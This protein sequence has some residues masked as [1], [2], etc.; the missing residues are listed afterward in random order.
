[1][2]YKNYILLLSLIM[3]SCQKTD[4]GSSTPVPIP[5]TDLTGSLISPSQINLSW[6]D[7]STNES[8][9]KI[10]RKTNT[11]QFSVIGTVGTDVTKFTDNGLSNNTSY[12]YR[13]YSY[14][15]GGNSPTY[16]N[17]ISINT[18]DLKSGLVAYFPFSGNV[19]DSSGNNVSSNL[20]GS[21]SLTN[22]R[23]GKNSS[24][25]LFSCIGFNAESRI[26][27]NLKT[28]LGNNFSISFWAKRNTSQPTGSGFNETEWMFLS[29]EGNDKL[30][31]IGI[32]AGTNFLLYG[33]Y[34]NHTNSN[35][36]I[37]NTWTHYVQTFSNG[38]FRIY[39]NG[40][41]ISSVQ[42][43][44]NI[45]KTVFIIGNNADL[46]GQ[47]FNGA[48]DDVRIYNNSIPLNVIEYLSKN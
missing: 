1:M 27:G 12:T 42:R 7:R 14:N 35:Y 11:S 9:F 19:S 3:Y 32:P 24:A 26:M 29:G 38:E 39:V 30:T 28:P 48:I 40:K 34:P 21:V 45:D 41:F 33:T 6:I 18:V 17:E 4:N 2:K 5:P 23:F 43:N 46:S 13:V 31:A 10:E 36:G 16:S 15:S 37:D 47:G 44:V 20:R 8:G 22:D 25:Y